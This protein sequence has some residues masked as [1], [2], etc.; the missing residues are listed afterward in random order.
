MPADESFF[1]ERTEQS[2]VKAKIVS[3][4]FSAWAAV[5]QKHWNTPMAYIDLYC[6]PGKY[7]DNSYSAPLLI[8]Q[9]VLDDSFLSSK[10]FFTFND[11]NQSYVDSL[12]QSIAQ[13]DSR[14]FLRGRISYSNHTIEQEFYKNEVQ[15][16][17]LALGYK[18]T[19]V[20]NRKDTAVL[21]VIN[22]SI[23]VTSMV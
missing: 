7:D 22:A 14:N 17:W 1:S 4:Y 6:G 10:M 3:D 23:F 19:G 16:N 13:I 20:I 15:A 11:R 9:K 2:A 8:V 21:S 12:K 18:T 5:I